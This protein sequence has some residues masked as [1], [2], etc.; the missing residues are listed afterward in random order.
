MKLLIN[1][2]ALSASGVTQVSV[3]FINECI[4]FPEHEYH[5]FLSKTIKSQLDLKLFPENFKF[6]SFSNHP[7]YGLSGLQTRAKL[8]RLEKEIKPDKVFSIF[9]PSWWTPGVPHL[10]GYAYPHYVYPDSPLFNILSTS[11]KIKISVLKIIHLFFLERNGK[12]YVSE[13]SDVS[14]RFEQLIS[15]KR[16]HFFTVNNTCNN[17]FLQFQFNKE[18]R[19]LPEKLKNEFRFLSLCTYSV[20]KNLDILNKI[21]PILDKNYPA[22]ELKFVL[23]IDPL[24]LEKNFTPEAKSRIIN[25]GRID[26]RDCPQLYSECDAVFLPTLLECFSAN[27]PEAMIMEKPILTSNL[28]FATTICKDAAVYFDPLNAVEIAQTL[29]EI[30]QNEGLRNQLI[31]NGKRVLNKLPTPTERARQYLD[32]CNLMTA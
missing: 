9:G 18:K 13:T 25:L 7:L 26:V 22:H 27:Y 21:I 17:Y 23:T 16:S 19:I 31:D 20:H 30:Q 10:Q 32:I 5:I 1:T 14:D 15:N 3:S 11:Q 6:Y 12:N 24:I 28:S 2:S 4:H 29:V 8:R